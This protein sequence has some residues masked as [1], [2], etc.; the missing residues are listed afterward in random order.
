M[1][2]RFFFQ[3]TVVLMASLLLKNWYLTDTQSR[4]DAEGG[5]GEAKATAEHKYQAGAPLAT[6]AA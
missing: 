6:S 5:T 3:S 2:S 1:F 4:P